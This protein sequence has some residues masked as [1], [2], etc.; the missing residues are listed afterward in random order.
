MKAWQ[1]VDT[2]RSLLDGEPATLEAGIVIGVSLAMAAVFG[3]IALR[4]YALGTER[5]R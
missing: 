3:A 4:L 2:C 1:S 5:R